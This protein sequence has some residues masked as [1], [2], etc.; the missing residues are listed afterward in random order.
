MNAGSSVPKE[1][2]GPPLHGD[3]A[4]ARA[5]RLSPESSST[6]EFCEPSRGPSGSPQG[7]EWQSREAEKQFLSFSFTAFKAAE[8]RI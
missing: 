5:A 6:I 4:P 8:V 3:K 7:G 1:A 2:L